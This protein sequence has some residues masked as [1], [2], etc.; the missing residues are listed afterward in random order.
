MTSAVTLLEVLGRPLR[1]GNLELAA[2]YEA[3]LTQSSGV[4]L[5]EV[6]RAQLR[7]AA[8]LRAS[9]PSLRTPDA[10][11][12]GAALSTGCTAFVTNDRRLPR[13]AGIKLLAISDYE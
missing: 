8:A 10:L 9:H 4:R 7:Q 3:F 13:L 12:V 11:Q 2:R 5:V 1:H 6:D